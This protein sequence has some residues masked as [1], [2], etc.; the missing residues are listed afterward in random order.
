MEDYMKVKEKKNKNKEERKQG[1]T[2][3]K[4]PGLELKQFT[5]FIGRPHAW[6]QCERQRWSVIQEISTIFRSATVL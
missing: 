4:K 3:R 5:L 6:L 1:N 2:R